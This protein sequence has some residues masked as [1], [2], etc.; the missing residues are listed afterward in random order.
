MA[1]AVDVYVA[2]VVVLVEACGVYH[3]CTGINNKLGI[4]R[5]HYTVYLAI[6]HIQFHKSVV[7]GIVLCRIVPG[8]KSCEQWR[9]NDCRIFK[10]GAEQLLTAIG[11]YMQ[12]TITAEGFKS[13]CYLALIDVG[14]RCTPQCAQVVV[15]IIFLHK[16]FCSI[17]VIKSKNVRD[18][19]NAKWLSNV[20]EN[21]YRIRIR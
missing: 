9:Y 6:R 12:T 2:V 8:G 7:V 17:S 18:T 13:F 11:A 3:G 21:R 5:Q 15:F 16:C 20:K 10:Y 14:L 4:I 1:V 19:R